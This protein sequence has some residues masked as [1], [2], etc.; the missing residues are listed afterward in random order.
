MTSERFEIQGRRRNH[1]EGGPVR[2]ESRLARAEKLNDALKAANM[3]AHE[4]FTVWV[5]RVEQG[6]SVSPVYHSVRTFRPHPSTSVIPDRLP[7]N[8]DSQ[9]IACVA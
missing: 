7:N 2:D 3:W 6:N 1:S 9:A 8:R 5:Y 4:G